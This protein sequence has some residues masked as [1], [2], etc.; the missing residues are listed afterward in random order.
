MTEAAVHGHCDE[1]FAA[2]REVFVNN[3]KGGLDV[4][5]SF[6]A[7]VEGEMVVDL[8][9][10][11]AD[12]ART[13]PWARDTIVNV[14]STTKTMT[15]LTA[16][17]LADRGVLD[18]HAPVARYWPEFAASGKEGVKVSHLLSHA[19]GLSGW[20]TPL[21]A[22]EL[23]DW[24]RICAL[25]AA[26]KP[27]WTPGEK[28]GYHA[29]SQGFLVGEVIRRASGK[30]V[31][32]VF[33]EEIAGPLGADFHI[34]LAAEHDARVGELIPPTTGL[35]KGQDPQSI[36]GRTLNNPVLTALE[37]RTRAWRAAEIPAA[38][39]FGHARSVAEVQTVLANRGVSKD[40]RIMSE[41]GTRRALE[42][43]IEG[44]DMVLGLPIKHGMGYGLP[45]EAM[46]LPSPNTCFWGGWGGSLVIADLDR[47]IC[48]AY[49]MNKMGEGTTGDLR[50][51]QLIMPVY[52]AL[53]AR[54]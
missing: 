10:G 19:A 8:W 51:F 25:L 24:S 30:T 49:V 16:L 27:W 43:Q 23:Y 37:P 44:V 29:L 15:A 48:C 20:D 4:G 12:A 17:L 38:G 7:T 50:A 52:Q 31:G 5:A 2:V 33:R 28:V 14:Y 13:R 42:P 9:G 53:A 22:E 35:G 6:A 39:G 3:L 11:F 21:R 36:A 1:R 45:G 18:L 41:A 34:G 40:K 26:Q 47:R 32:T 54:T 46:P